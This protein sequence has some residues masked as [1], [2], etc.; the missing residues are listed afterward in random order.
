M[1]G[2]RETWEVEEVE[3]RWGER[4]EVERRWVEVGRGWRISCGGGDP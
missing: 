2:R 1:E 4:V 3:R